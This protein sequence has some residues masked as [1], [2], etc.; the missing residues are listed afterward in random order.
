MNALGLL[1]PLAALALKGLPHPASLQC[2][3]WLLLWGVSLVAPLALRLAGHYPRLQVALALTSLFMLLGYYFEGNWL[4]FASALWLAATLAMAVQVL[5]RPG[6]ATLKLAF[7][8]APIGGIW[9]VASAWQHGLMGFDPLMTL[10]TADHFC[11]VTL[12]AMVWASQ[13]QSQLGQSGRWLIRL[14]WISPAFV[15][16]GI[17]L[18]HYLGRVTLV[19]CLGVTAQV[20]ATSGISLLWLVRGSPNPVLTVSALCSLLTMGLALDYAWGRW[21]PL[22]HLELA[23]MIPYHGLVNALGFVTIGLTAWNYRAT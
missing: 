3:Q 20:T 9:A 19:E 7:L 10:L 6:D 13:A 5:R 4:T 2:A 1:P 12:G 17:T 18:S 23:W 22:N 21:F 14:L 15:A 11:Y 8:Y 16:L